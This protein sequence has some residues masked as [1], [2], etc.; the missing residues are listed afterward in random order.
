VTF[1]FGAVGATV[2]GAEVVLNYTTGEITG[3]TFAGV[4]AGW[5][6]AISMTGNIGLVYGLQPTNSNYSKGFEGLSGS[7]LGA[8]AYAA[9]SSPLGA[10]RP[11][12]PAT[13][14]LT[15]GAALLGKAGVGVSKTSYGAPRQLG[16]LNEGPGINYGT[17][18]DRIML[19]AHQICR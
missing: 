13:A 11:G 7:Y 15:G 3:F 8:G 1:G 5:N 10:T 2:V 19:V 12:L 4:Q 17:A 14:G 18:F 16:N 6:G 9:A